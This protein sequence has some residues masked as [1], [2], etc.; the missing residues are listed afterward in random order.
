MVTED[1]RAALGNDY[2][3]MTAAF[4]HMGREGH[5]DL[6]G[7]EFRKGLRSLTGKRLSKAQ[8]DDLMRKEIL[9]K[10]IL[11]KPIPGVRDGAARRAGRAAGHRDAAA[12]FPLP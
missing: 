6:T 3:A 10:E 12:Q 11:R 8:L 9:R 5:G 1:I 2:A 4:R 7:A